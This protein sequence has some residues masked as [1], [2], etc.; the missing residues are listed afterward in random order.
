MLEG[1]RFQACNRR[2]PPLPVVVE[3][4]VVVLHQAMIVPT[5]QD[6]EEIDPVLERPL[7]VEPVV[8]TE[9]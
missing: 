6:G 9:R 5:I 8:M 1:L 4:V 7:S 2:P 3:S